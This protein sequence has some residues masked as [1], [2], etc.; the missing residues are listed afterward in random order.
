MTFTYRDGAFR[1]MKITGPSHHL[2]G[3]VLSSKIEDSEQRV[4]DL[5]KGESINFDLNQIKKLVNQGIE[6]A[7]RDYGVNYYAKEIQIVGDDTPDE[8]RYFELAYKIVERLA[9]GEEF[10]R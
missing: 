10:S 6:D 9:K 3:L 2:L 5:M 4:I 1:V 7:N 8:N